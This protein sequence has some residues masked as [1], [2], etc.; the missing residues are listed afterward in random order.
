MR[1]S[2]INHSLSLNV[3]WIRNC[4]RV[5]SCTFVLSMYIEMAHKECTEYAPFFATVAEFQIY[6]TSNQ[7]I[8]LTAVY[9]NQ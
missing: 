6:S 4:E 7:K 8:D 5:G 1:F 9:S 3:D 2:E